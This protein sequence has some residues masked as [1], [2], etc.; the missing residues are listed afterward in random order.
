MPSPGNWN[1]ALH[2]Y[3]GL[4][5]LFF[6]WL[7]SFTGLLL[8]HPKWRFADF[9]PLRKQDS[10]THAIARP[11]AGAG[12]AQ[13]QDILRQ[14]GYAGEIQWTTAQTSPDRLNF[15]AARPGSVLDID[16]DLKKGV[17]T[18][19]RVRYNGW[20]FVRILHVFTGVRAGDQRHERDWVLTRLWV[21]AMDATA[22]G[23]I[24]L[25]LG[26][27]YMWWRL[28][29]KRASGALALALGA[30]VC[31]FFVFVLRWL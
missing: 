27:Y 21:F 16:A 5:L 10:F 25:V 22:A 11:P 20:G 28:P 19:A 9:W 13:A 14:I 1:R 7:F 29:G 15:R 17:A 8:N 6:F 12:L 30:V 31:G 26:S 24:V 23:L 4:Y 3:C 2:I 18:I